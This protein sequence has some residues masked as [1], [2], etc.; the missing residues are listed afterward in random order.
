VC[1]SEILSPHSGVEGSS[2]LVCYACR[3]M[4]SCRSFGEVFASI[5]RVKQWK[6][7]RMLILSKRQLDTAQRPRR[8][9]SPNFCAH[10]REPASIF[11]HIKSELLTAN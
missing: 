2:L 8:L 1:I 9:E 7:L 10:L 5:F 4:K 11:D 6:F 3:L